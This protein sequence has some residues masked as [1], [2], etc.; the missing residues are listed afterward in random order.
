MERLRAPR[1][2]GFKKKKTADLLADVGGWEIPEKN[3]VLMAE[4]WIWRLP[5]ADFLLLVVQSGLLGTERL[6]VGKVNRN[7]AGKRCCDCGALLSDYRSSRCR[8]C[9]DKARVGRPRRCAAV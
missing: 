1:A 7:Y 4:H 8:G 6:R 9:A 5:A 3:G 2:N